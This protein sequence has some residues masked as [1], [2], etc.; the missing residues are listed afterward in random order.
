MYTK[1]IK[2]IFSYDCISEPYEQEKVLGS[3]DN[4]FMGNV[5]MLYD[6]NQ[7]RLFLLLDLGG[8]PRPIK[9]SE[10]ECKKKVMKAINKHFPAD[11][12]HITEEVFKFNFKWFD[13]TEG[14]TS[15]HKIIN[16]YDFIPSEETTFSFLKYIFE[17]I[18]PSDKRINIVAATDEDLPSQ[19]WKICEIM[20]NFNNSHTKHI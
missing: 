17:G 12:Q 2:F 18:N 3:I 13:G 20:N 6:P 1:D 5:Q 10:K 4:T 14:F 16:N 9:I 19:M 15:A 11:P 8:D 7:L